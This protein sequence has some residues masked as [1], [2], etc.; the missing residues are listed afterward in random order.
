MKKTRVLLADDHKMML[1]GLRGILESE[2][3]IEGTAEDGR[4]LL[5]EAKRLSPDV[6]VADISMPELNGIDAARQIRKI[7]E[8]IRIGFRPCIQM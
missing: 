4:V 1:E 6:V 5:A 2:F 7:H 3:E 8:R